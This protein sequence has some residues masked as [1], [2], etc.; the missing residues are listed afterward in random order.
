MFRDRLFTAGNLSLFLV[1]LGMGAI[2]LFFPF[3]LQ[4]I[5]GYSAT[6]MG[7]ILMA[8]SAVI[9]FCSPIG[10]WLS[11]RFGSRLL[12]TSGAILMTVAYGMIGFLNKTSPIYQIVF[13]HALSGLAWALFNSPNASAVFTSAGPRKYGQ[14]SGILVTMFS[15]GQALG[16]VVG[17]LILELWTSSSGVSGSTEASLDAWRATPD[18]FLM[19]FRAVCAF[20]AVVQIGAAFGSAVRGAPRASVEMERTRAETSS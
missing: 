7:L 8:D 16:V 1:A 15:V 18:L 14:A 12:C 10:G 17:T 20:S 3:Y 6:Q 13:P 4:G 2:T 19:A 9:V 11:D 5:R